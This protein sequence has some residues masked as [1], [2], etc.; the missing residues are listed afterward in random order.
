MFTRLR[1][2]WATGSPLWQRLMAYGTLAVVAFAA[3]QTVAILGGS[4][5]LS[6]GLATVAAV[7]LCVNFFLLTVARARGERVYSPGW[8][9]KFQRAAR[10]RAAGSSR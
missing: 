1:R 8:Y 7:V 6:L 9:R 5:W 10:A 2:W 4:M 3:G